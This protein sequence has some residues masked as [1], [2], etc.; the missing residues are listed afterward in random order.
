MSETGAAIAPNIQ[1]ARHSYAIPDLHGIRKKGAAVTT[2][3]PTGFLEQIH[4]N[5]V[6][7]CFAF[8]S[9]VNPELRTCGKAIKKWV[10]KN[11]GQLAA[12]RRSIK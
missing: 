1:D 6:R 12:V 2:G 3:I 9:P 10:S 5:V 8:T 4:G 7:S 11:S